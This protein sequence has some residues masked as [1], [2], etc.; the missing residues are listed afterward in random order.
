MRANATP[1]PF[2][3]RIEAI[4]GLGAIA[5]AFVHF[6]Y[7]AYAGTPLL[8]N[9][10][11]TE[12]LR[13]VVAAGEAH[14]IPGHACLM[15]FF[16]ISGF[17]LRVALEQSWTTP[18]RSSGQFM[19]KRLLRVYPIT[20]FGVT[21]TALCTT[22]V[23]TD[24]GAPAR[25]VSSREFINNLLL[26]DVS[27][28]TTWW[29]LRVE[30]LCAPLMVLLYLL[31]RR[32]GTR[33]LVLVTIVTSGLI[34][35][36]RWAGDV[37]VSCHFFAIALGMTTPTVGRALIEAMGRGPLRMAL[38]FCALAFVGIGPVCGTYSHWSRLVEAYT[39]WGFV[40][41]LAYRP[42]GGGWRLL[43]HP[44]LRHMGRISGSF[45]VLHMLLGMLF[46]HHLVPRLLPI[47][48]LH[49]SPWLMGPSV[50]F[51]FVLCVSGCAWATYHFIEVPGIALGRRLTTPRETE[52]RQEVPCH[53]H[54]GC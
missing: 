4:R 19:V 22:F 28:N 52:N 16:V 42:L 24:G 13:H 54:A 17:V 39:A 33:W 35:R 47:V 49:A 15:L 46:F 5:V 25:S 27:L 7:V 36:S 45:Y 40:S 50:L 51:L 14:L 2:F 44:L 26:V 3:G 23:G 29:A 9:L 10:R 20:I 31:E 38:A 32:W 53:R 18:F 30:V 48:W 43:D 37:G 21:L 1:R 8:P 11:T 12:P 34:F 6:S 41:A